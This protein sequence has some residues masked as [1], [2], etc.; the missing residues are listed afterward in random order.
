MGSKGLYLIDKKEGMNGEFGKLVSMM[1]YTRMTT[2][3]EVKNLTAEQLDFLVNEDANSIGM[4]LEHMNSVEKAYQ[5]DTFEK[6][7]YTEEDIQVLNPGLELG[8]AARQQ[9]KGNPIEFYLEQL[10]QT[11]EKTIE[12]FS[13][14]PDTWLF[15]QAPFWDGE[16]ANNYFKWFHVMEDEL[17]HR[18]QIRL[19]KKIMRMTSS[20][21]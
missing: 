13:K 4:L 11:R 20:V 16:P 18:G 9:I 14:L 10:E 8:E 15:E 17:N 1:D 19:I 12:T 21:I 3:A 6:R 5:I 2:V 7:E